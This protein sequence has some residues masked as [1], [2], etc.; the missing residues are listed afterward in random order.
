MNC[1]GFNEFLAW[2]D[3]AS[4]DMRK[5]AL[6]HAAACE[7]CRAVAS[8][9]EEFKRE[10]RDDGKDDEDPPE[11]RDAILRYAAEQSELRRRARAPFEV[12]RPSRAR[13]LLRAASLV[14][15][16]AGSFLVGRLSGTIPSDPI[17]LRLRLAEAE[18]AAGEVDR[19][20][21][22]AT[23]VLTAPAATLGDRE[24]AK[25]ILDRKRP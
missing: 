4:E 10:L 8:G 19:A 23:Q 22:E 14:G 15:A 5:D 6:Q 17:A 18:L 12:P 2:G 21:A 1:D 3:E 25:S 9:F 7:E 11:V 13:I 24:W 16:T 20:H